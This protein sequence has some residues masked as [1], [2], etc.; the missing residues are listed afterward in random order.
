M[1]VFLLRVMNPFLGDTSLSQ[2]RDLCQGF[3]I[4]S[5]RESTVKGKNLLP[6]APHG[7]KF[8]PFRVDPFSEGF[9][10]KKTK[11]EAIKSYLP[12]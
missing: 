6:Y 9:V 10:A 4:P 11:K 1:S 5:E 12:C 7:S 8:F 2:G 3:H